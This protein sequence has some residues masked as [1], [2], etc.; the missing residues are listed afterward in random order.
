MGAGGRN[1]LKR[2]IATVMELPKDIMLNLPM[3][4]LT[5]DEE[6]LISNHKGLVE[7]GAGHVRVATT[8]GTAKIFGTNLVLKEITAETIVIAGKINQVT[9]ETR[10]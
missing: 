3:V 10:G 5:G 8:I 6:I 1:N 9:W 2:K 7:Y 4:T